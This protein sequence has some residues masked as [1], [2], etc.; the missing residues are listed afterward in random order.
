[1]NTPRNDPAAQN[2]RL[3]WPTWMAGPDRA[4]DTAAAADADT[5][6]LNRAALHDALTHDH[7][8]ARRQLRA[9]A[10][11]EDE[12]TPTAARPALS[13]APPTAD[14]PTATRPDAARPPDTGPWLTLMILGLVIVAVMLVVTVTWT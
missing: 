13:T 10:T 11:V 6:V 4:A 9:L 12:T 5:V 1:M 14:A 2:D 3:S 8:P 7:R